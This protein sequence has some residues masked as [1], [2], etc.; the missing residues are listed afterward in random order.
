MSKVQYATPTGVKGPFW[1]L[2]ED[3]SRELEGFRHEIESSAHS[4][5]LD[6]PEV[7]L[8]TAKAEPETLRRLNSL[9]EGR[10]GE[11][12]RQQ[13]IRSGEKRCEAILE[14]LGSIRS[15]SP[16]RDFT[17]LP[18]LHQVLVRLPRQNALEWLFEVGRSMVSQI[19]PNYSLSIPER[20]KDKSAVVALGANQQSPT[21]AN[22]ALAAVAPSRPWWLV[23][24]GFVQMHSK[25]FL[26]EDEIVGVLDSGIFSTHSHLSSKLAQYAEFDTIGRPVPSPAVSDEGCHGTKVSSVLVGGRPSTPE[27]AAPGAKVAVAKVL[28]GPALGENGTLAQ[29]GAGAQWLLQEKNAGMNV[30]VVNISIE[31]V[32]QDP[33]LVAA[34]TALSQLNFLGVKPV[35]AVGNHG[36]GT[37]TLLARDCLVVGACDRRG[38]PWTLSGDNPDLLA[39]GIEMQ[40]AQPPLP[41]LGSADFDQYNGTSL[42]TSVV[43]GALAVLI[44]ATRRSVDDCTNAILQAAKSSSSNKVREQRS[45]W[46][47]LNVWDAYCVLKSNRGTIPAP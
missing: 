3:S 25:G 12:L 42:A 17:A 10:Q 34:Q 22:V 27:S 21:Q 15:F 2:A 33:K 32:R 28:G 31:V 24:A 5:S 6:V 45:G 39:P 14:S 4:R 11:D 44:A 43:S 19:S 35:V 7:L 41:V 13:L 20:A 23:H 38:S 9:H 30:S 26:G 37:R 36:Q 40:C 29:L 46:G 8:L 18:M 47:G 1:Y 16:D